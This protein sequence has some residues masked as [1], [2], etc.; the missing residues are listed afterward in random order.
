ML[1]TTHYLQE[2]ETLCDR[3]GIVDHG[4]LLALDSLENLLAAHGGPHHIHLPG[5]E[6]LPSRDPW[7]TLQELAREGLPPRFRVESPDLEQV[8]L[9]LTGRALRD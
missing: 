3:I 1:Y 4:R 9:D 5:R 6:P 2:A 8:F 7:H